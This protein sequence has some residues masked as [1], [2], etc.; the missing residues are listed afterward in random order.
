V[1]KDFFK[2]IRITTLESNCKLKQGT[3]HVFSKC[4]FESEISLINGLTDPVIVK[5]I[6]FILSEDVGPYISLKSRPTALKNLQ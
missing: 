3:G 2:S 1:N 6:Q 5:D 4:T